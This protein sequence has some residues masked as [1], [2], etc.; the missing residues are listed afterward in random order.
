M[1]R[2][3][4]S[5]RKLI[6]S[7]ILNKLNKGEEA[8]LSLSE[9]LAIDMNILFCSIFPNITYDTTAV[10]A[11]GF[12]QKIKF[13]SDILAKNTNPLESF[14]FLL[15]HSS[16][17]A[18]AWACFL[19][20]YLSKQFENSLQIMYPLI[21]DKHFLVREWAWISLREQII[22]NLQY[23]IN[24]L[25][26]KHENHLYRR[27]VSEILR[28]RGVWCK[29]ITVF[30]NNQN[31][32]LDICVPILKYFSNEENRYVQNSV[33]N[34]INDC[35]K[36]NLEWIKQI[37]SIWDTSNPHTKYILKRGFRNFKVSIPL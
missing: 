6:P 23:N 29:H 24:L 1:I 35:A 20:P 33:G 16:D 22:D 32:I 13:F 15:Q 27:F 18:R 9:A 26:Y 8:T 37:C 31:N 17:T 30:K 10:K 25:N 12:I 19:V 7:E 4:F 28:P 34:W 5:S 21:L 14:N 2:K 11:L 3:G 36:D